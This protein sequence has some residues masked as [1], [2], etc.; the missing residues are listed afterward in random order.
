M[1]L[2]GRALHHGHARRHPNSVQM[3]HLRFLDSETLKLKLR[4]AIAFAVVFGVCEVRK[5][6]LRGQWR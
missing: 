6:E 2:V 3:V 4:V 5:S 1:P